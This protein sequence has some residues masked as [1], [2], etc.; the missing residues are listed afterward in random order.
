MKKVFAF[1]L[2]LVII[3]LSFAACGKNE[4]KSDFDVS[5]AVEKA[6]GANAY[7][8]CNRNY[9]DVR[10]TMVDSMFME[11][12]TDGTYTCTGYIAIYDNYGDVYKGKYKATV[13]VNVESK[14]ANC[15]E[16]TMVTTPKKD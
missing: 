6:I 13:G 11:T 14:K 10:L 12:N 8:Y 2:A 7:V 3:A 9:A 15:T 4:E 5:S 16:F 1:T